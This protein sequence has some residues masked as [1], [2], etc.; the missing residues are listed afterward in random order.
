MT[1]DEAVIEGLRATFAVMLP[2]LDERQQRWLLASESIALGHGGTIAV[3]RASGASRSRVVHGIREITAHAAGACD[4]PPA[5]KARRAAAGRPAA[6]IK[7]EGLLPQLLTYIEPT[8]RGD[9]EGPLSWTTWSTRALAKA[10][11]ESGHQ[12]GP[13]TVR[14]LLRDNNFSLQGNLKTLEGN[15]HEDR[16]GQFRHIHALITEFQGS[17]DPVI[18]VDAKKKEL[19][20]A[21]KNNGRTWR[22]VGEPEQVNVH[23]FLNPNLGKANPYGVYD[24]TRNTGWVSVGTSKDT[25][26]FAVETIRRWWHGA[27]KID[28]PR[29]A[30]LLIT[31]DGGGSNGSRTRLWK[32][33]L[34]TLATELGITIT[35]AHLPPGTSKWNKIEHRLFSYIS[36]NW[37]GTPLTSVDLIIKKIASTTTEATDLHP[38]L[39]V[40]AELDDTVYETGI[41]V[42][43]EEMRLLK[44]TGRWEPEEWHPEWNYTIHTT[45]KD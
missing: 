16:D 42:P 27:G 4:A 25:S 24:L 1:I 19:V 44:E 7:D 13:E 2:L 20:G 5:S 15:Q 28:Y 33:E 37:R 23:D 29:A 17:K 43:D 21:F 39:R 14:N 9:P 34:A 45:S 3:M 40:H 41:K 11:T 32:R 26:E 8:R 10:L 36:I 18:S 38:G 30:R 35:V 6:A 22:P 12:V 31:A